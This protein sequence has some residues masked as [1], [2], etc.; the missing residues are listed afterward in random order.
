MK[1]A[2]WDMTYQIRTIWS[3]KHIHIHTQHQMQDMSE[4]LIKPPRHFCNA[5]PCFQAE[6]GM[7][8]CSGGLLVRVELVFML[9]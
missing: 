1:L 8:D 3:P 6:N 4:M 2:M 9:Q 7:A 5:H